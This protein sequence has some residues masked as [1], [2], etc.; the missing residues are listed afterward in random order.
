MKRAYPAVLGGVAMAVAVAACGTSSR[1]SVDVPT[2]GPATKTAT[3]T[4]TVSTPTQ[5]T[6]PA[7]SACTASDLTPAS[8]GSNGAMGHVVVTFSLRNT[9]ER[10]CHSYGFPGVQ[11]MAGKDQPV[12]TH[13]T[14]TVH[15]FAGDTP[16]KAI[17]LAPGQSAEFRVVLSDVANR[18][19]RCV[20]ADALQIIAPD[21]TVPML[22][23][24]QNPVSVCGGQATVSPLEPSSPGV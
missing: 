11:F 15:D 24:L 22:A 23:T 2:A 13:A 1:T 19:L 18:R 7:G 8:L 14:R 12:P 20:T 10:T 16:L 3:V 9:G 17:T 6:T 4:R 5:T 21:D